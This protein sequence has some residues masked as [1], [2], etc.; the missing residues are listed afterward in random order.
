MV[1]LDAPAAIV[2]PVRCREDM[3]CWVWSRMGNRKRGIRT[4]VGRL[5][6]VGP[7]QFHMLWLPGKVDLTGSRG[8]SSQPMRGDWWAVL[9]GCDA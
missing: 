1:A 4:M 2:Q 8:A 5:R 7:C 6:V 3:P 9:H